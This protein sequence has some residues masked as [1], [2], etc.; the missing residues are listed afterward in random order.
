MLKTI[1]WNYLRDKRFEMAREYIDCNSNK[2]LLDIGCDIDR[3]FIKSLKGMKTIGIDLQLGQK[4]EKKLDFLNN[5]FDYVTRLATIEHLEYP[6]EIL[7][8]CSRILKN[9]GLLI[10]TTPK[11]TPL[12]IIES[13]FFRDK[14]KIYAN[15]HMFNKNILNKMALKYFNLKVYKSFEF[16]LNQL[17]VYEK[18]KHDNLTGKDKLN[19]GSPTE[20]LY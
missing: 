2:A 8:E 9:D 6:E 17:F 13:I 7:R 15:V 1:I 14:L 20:I 16:D 10:I 19:I 18:I 11:N 4:V 3:I 5:S 12:H